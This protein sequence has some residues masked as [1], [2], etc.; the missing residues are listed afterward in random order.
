MKNLPARFTNPKMNTKKETKMNEIIEKNESVLHKYFEGIA[1][2][3]YYD[4]TSYQLYLDLDDNTMSIKQEI[5]DNTW[6]QRDDGSL[7][8]L[9]KTSGYADIPEEERY[10]DD[11]DLY[12]YGYAEWLDGIE[13][14]LLQRLENG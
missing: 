11:C 6:S 3:N 13:E 5:S 4:G 14:I 10:S 2:C 1:S 8:C 12:D 9:L 7:I